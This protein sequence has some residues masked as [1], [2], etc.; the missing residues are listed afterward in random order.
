[1]KPFERSGA[2]KEPRGMKEG[3]KREERLDR[4][5]MEPGRAVKRSTKT[6]PVKDFLVPRKN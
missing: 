1:M 2:D 3:S 6:Q 5:Q 4:M